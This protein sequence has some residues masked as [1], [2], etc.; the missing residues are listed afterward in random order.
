MKTGVIILT[1]IVIGIFLYRRYH[2]DK[3]GIGKL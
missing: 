3:N 1:M 2:S